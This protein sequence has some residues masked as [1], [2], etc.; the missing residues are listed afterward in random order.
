MIGEIVADIIG[1]IILSL[2]DYPGAYV[3]WL[4]RKK[5]MPFKEIEARYFGINLLLSVVLYCAIAW[6]IYTII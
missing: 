1:N 3:H 4:L 2:V 6:I 5:R